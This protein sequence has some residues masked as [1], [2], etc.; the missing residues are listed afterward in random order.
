VHRHLLFSKSENL[1]FK[2]EE[3]EMP[4]VIISKTQGDEVDFIMHGNPKEP[5]MAMP[6]DPSD[7]KVTVFA[8]LPVAMSHVNG[9]YAYATEM[10]RKTGLPPNID[11]IFNLEVARVVM[12]EEGLAV[13]FMLPDYD[14]ITTMK[15]A[16]NMCG[17]YGGCGGKQPDMVDRFIE[18]VF[19]DAPEKVKDL[20]REVLKD[21]EEV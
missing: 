18:D 19:G 9:F 12:D 1:N 17:V 6:T 13:D 21:A 4:Y 16:E 11:D 7:I 8:D 20:M 14:N 15:I 2:N 5:M 10:Q 3:N